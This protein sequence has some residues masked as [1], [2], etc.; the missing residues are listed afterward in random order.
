[1][2]IQEH[3]NPDAVKVIDLA[4]S[5]RSSKTFI[6]EGRWSKA[7]AEKPNFVLIQF[8]HNDSHPASRPEATNPATDFKHYLR[9]YINDA[10]AIH[11]TPILVT[12]MARRVFDAQG[13]ISDTPPPPGGGLLPYCNAMKDVANELNVPLIDLH[14]ASVALF[15]KLGP[16]ASAKLANKSGDSTH[17][18]EQGARDMADLVIQSL[19]QAAPELA[20]YLKSK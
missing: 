3:F 6:S 19:P 9:Q 20:Q 10:R 1:M 14:T 13:K 17:F 11:A 5:G 2:F 7:L 16:D 12:P 15:E 8:G 4:A 18:N